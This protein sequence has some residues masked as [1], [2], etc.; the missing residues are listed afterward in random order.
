MACLR[1]RFFGGARRGL[2]R[3]LAHLLDSGIGAT[4]IVAN[5]GRDLTARVLEDRQTL[6]RV[7]QDA[8]HRVLEQLYLGQ[9]QIPRRAT[10][11]EGLQAAQRLFVVRLDRGQLMF[12]ELFDAVVDR[13]VGRRQCS[14]VIASQRI[15]VAADLR[16]WILLRTRHDEKRP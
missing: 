15:D 12:G 7:G 3:R 10:L 5:L 4:Q 9:R 14:S 16:D 6:T 8:I 1:A 13:L 11:L 2:L